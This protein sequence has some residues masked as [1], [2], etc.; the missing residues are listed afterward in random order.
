[1]SKYGNLFVWL[2][3]KLIQEVGYTLLLVLKRLSIGSSHIPIIG[4]PFLK[5]AIGYILKTLHLPI[6]E[7]DFFDAVIPLGIR[8]TAERGQAYTAG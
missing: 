3:A 7:V 6:T 1:M 4:I 8:V 5:V 2:L